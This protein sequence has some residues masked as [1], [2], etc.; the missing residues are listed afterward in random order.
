MKSIMKYLLILSMFCFGLSTCSND[1]DAPVEIEYESMGTLHGFDGALCACCG[2]WVVTLEDTLIDYRIE[3]FPEG[4][5]V[6][7]DELPREIELN[8][9]FNRDCQSIMYIDVEDIRYVE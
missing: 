4:F 3:V 9:T 7:S 2:S 1:D 5:E 8:W 6:N